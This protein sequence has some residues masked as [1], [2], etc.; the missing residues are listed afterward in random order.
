MLTLK[1]PTRYR[2]PLSLQRLH[3]YQDRAS[4]PDNIQIL[5]S[6]DE[7]DEEMNCDKFLSEI[8]T[9]PSVEVHIGKPR[10]K[11]SA[12]NADLEFVRGDCIALVADD[13]EV[14]IRDYD[15]K[16]LR[17]LY[18]AFPD[19]DGVLHYDDGYR[20]DG[21]A[22]G[23]FCTQP[24]VGRKYLDRFGYIFHPSYKS[25]FADNE[26]HVVAY[27]LERVKRIPEVVFR[28]K[29]QEIPCSDPL[30]Q[31]DFRNWKEDEATYLHRFRCGFPS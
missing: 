30:R 5:V 29:W 6:I 18:E 7:D 4:S 20:T 2:R 8:A 10:D 25:V 11:I 22:G 19:T 28:H 31:R 12:I 15:T 3:E 16:V 24:V 26:F 9:M 13:T 27:T 21:M 1:Y 17:D 14:D 23:K